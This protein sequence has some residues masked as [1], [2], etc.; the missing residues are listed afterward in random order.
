MSDK[1]SGRRNATNLLITTGPDV[2]LTPMGGAMVPV[3]YSC[4]AF[5]EPAE[6]LSSSVRNN[7]RLDFQLNTRSA[8][9]TGHEPGTGKGVKVPGYLAYS[10]VETASSSVFSEGFAVVRDRDPAWLNHP[11]PGPQEPRR[12]VEEHE[13]AS[14]WDEA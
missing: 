9:I 8:R 11:T 5:L 7:T 2:C 6:R 1:V 3:A 12:E 13:I 4:V 10:H 14:A